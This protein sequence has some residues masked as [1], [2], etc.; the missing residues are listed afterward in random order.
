[1]IQAETYQTEI[2]ESSARI[3]EGLRLVY[4][5]EWLSE[6]ARVRG[7]TQLT[8]NLAYNTVDTCQVVIVNKSHVTIGRLLRD[9]N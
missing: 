9:F 6:T 2:V 3:P 1:M 7:V 5:L 4:G 8:D